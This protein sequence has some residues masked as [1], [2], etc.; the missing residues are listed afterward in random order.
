MVKDKVSYK[1]LV[2]EDNEGDFYLVKDYLEEL[3]LDPVIERARSYKEIKSI[4]QSMGPV[5]FDVILLDLTLPDNSG[6]QLIKDMLAQEPGVPIIVLTG[7]T[8]FTFAVRSL[9]LGVSDYLLKDDLTSTT[10]YKSVVYNIE[11]YKNLKSLKDSEQRYADLFHLSPQPMWVYDMNTLA[12]LDVNEAA[13]K[14][15]GYS[16]EE[17]LTMTIKQIRPQEDIEELENF[18]SEQKEIRH[19]NYGNIFRHQ[20]KNGEIVHVDIRSNIIL[21]NGKDAK[22]ILANDV[23]ERL[24]HQKAIELQNQKLRQI[25]WD[26]SHVV[27]AP[28]ARMLGLIHLIN[29]E[30]ISH[31]EKLAMMNFLVDSAHELDKIVIDITEKAQQ[32]I[33]TDTF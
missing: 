19:L 25:A 13:I 2:I 24:K 1:I 17:F 10:L 18:I 20:K 5:F 27:R 22:I 12:F 3:I 15:Y 31:D 32:I 30:A 6:T 26:Q 9:A 28:L 21:F 7:Y 29:D 23:T 33:P 16:Y 4:L 11:R 8:D 14:F